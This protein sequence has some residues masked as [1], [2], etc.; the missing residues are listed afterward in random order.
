MSWRGRSVLLTGHTGFKGA[1]LALWLHALGA[2]VTGFGGPPPTEPSLFALAG[3][4]EVLQDLRGDVCDAEAVRAAARRARPDVVF[5][6]AA[7][8]LVARGFEDPAGTFATNVG[9]TVN[10]L[11]ATRGVPTVVV[12]SDKCY[13]PGPDRH[14]EGDPLGGGDPYSAS[15]AAQEQV[16]AAYRA[17]FDL[18]LATVRAGN[19]IGGGDYA[20]GRL[21]PDLA[22]AQAAG[23]A[24][25]IRHP[26]AVRPWQHVL[27]P[28]AGY[29]RVAEGLLAGEPVAEAWNFGPEPE[30]ERPV[31]WLVERWGVAMVAGAAEAREAP[32][33]R[34]D[35][36]KARAR[37]GWRPAWDLEVG[38]DAAAAWYAADDARAATVE[39]IARFQE[40]LEPPIPS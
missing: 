4:G 9:G 3:V 35:S 10:V 22:R 37:L 20:P 38:L 36:S 26:D 13:A 27:N 18:P 7:Q 29:L 19:A 14:A 12:T 16:A 39:Q 33:L 23:E 2:R 15:K 21:I 17:A 32:A 5:H 40:A 34:V 8:S 28:L 11:E 31:R 1:W 25:A 30:D 6:L 24:V